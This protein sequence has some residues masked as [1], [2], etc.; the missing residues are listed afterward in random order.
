MM[1]D[2]LRRLL[3]RCRASL[4]GCLHESELDLDRPERATTL[5]RRI[6]DIDTALGLQ[7]GQ[8][9]PPADGAITDPGWGI[10]PPV[11]GR[12]RRPA[13]LTPGRPVG[14]RGGGMGKAA[15]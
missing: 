1:D 9:E 13:S 14:F 12:V 7:D 11:G 5:T 8:H 6:A 10:L 4:L 3:I 15:S 2:A